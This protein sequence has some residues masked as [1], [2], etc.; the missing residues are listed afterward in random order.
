MTRLDQRL[1]RMEAKRSSIREE[2]AALSDEELGRRLKVLDE[3]CCPK[4]L[5]GHAAE[6]AASL[7]IPNPIDLETW[8]GLDIGSQ[9]KILE[10]IIGPEEVARLNRI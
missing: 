3:Q 7:D 5:N 8:R 2:L 9:V 10:A 1:R 6:F 4:A